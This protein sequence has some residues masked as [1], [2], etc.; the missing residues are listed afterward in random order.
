MICRLCPRECG[1]D[2]SAFRVSAAW[3]APACRAALHQWEEPCISGDPD[4]SQ[5]GS[6][7]VFPAA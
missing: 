3:E 2:R 7:T 4:D 5:T 6:G 1:V